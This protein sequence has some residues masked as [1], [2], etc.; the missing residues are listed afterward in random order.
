MDWST[1]HVYVFPTNR[2]SSWSAWEGNRMRP[3]MQFMLAWV[4]CFLSVVISMSSCIWF[5]VYHIYVFVHVPIRNRCRALPLAGPENRDLSASFLLDSWNWQPITISKGFLLFH[6][7][8]TQ[9]AES[10]TDF[11]AK[12][13]NRFI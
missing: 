13:L 1:T 3:L 4:L 5:C 7:F 6:I 10:S 12:I 9:K 8:K 2:P 11:Q